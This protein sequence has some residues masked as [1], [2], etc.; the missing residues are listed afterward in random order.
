MSYYLITR[1]GVCGTYYN[2]GSSREE[3]AHEHPG[4]TATKTQILEVR[5]K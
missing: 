5:P 4:K 2:Q 1:C 3:K